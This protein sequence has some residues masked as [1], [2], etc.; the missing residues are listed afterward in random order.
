MLEGALRTIAIVNKPYNAGLIL[1]VN[2]EARDASTSE[3]RHCG[4][5]G[6]VDLQGYCDA[7]DELMAQVLDTQDE[8]ADWDF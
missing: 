7:C 8:Y 5:K 1:C 3:C 4:R 6:K 2:C